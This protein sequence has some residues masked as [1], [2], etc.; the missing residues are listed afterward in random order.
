SKGP[1]SLMA[2]RD[3]VLRSPDMDLASGLDYENKLFALCIASGERDEGVEAF[4]AKRK[5]RFRQ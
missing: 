1:V 5:A 4:L 2:A 3:A